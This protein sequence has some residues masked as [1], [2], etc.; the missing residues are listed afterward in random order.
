MSQRAATP[1]E[2]IDIV[3]TRRA[4]REFPSKAN[5]AGVEGG[6]GPENRK[7]MRPA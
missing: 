1:R 7:K 5:G 3:E 4:G 2:D 6:F